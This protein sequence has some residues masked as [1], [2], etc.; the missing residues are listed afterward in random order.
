MYFMVPHLPEIKII[1]TEPVLK[2]FWVLDGCDGSFYV[3]PWLGEGYW[4][5]QLNSWSFV[6]QQ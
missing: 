3:S 4:L 5:K 1:S 6:M 2:F